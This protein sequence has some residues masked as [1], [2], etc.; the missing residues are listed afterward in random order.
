MKRILSIAV[1]DF[2]SSI[3]DFI[4]IYIIVSPIVLAFLIAGFVPSTETASVTIGVDQTIDNTIV[5]SLEAYVDVEAFETLEKMKN[6]V[7]ASDDFVGL[8]MAS[9]EGFEVIREGNEQDDASELIRNLLIKQASEVSGEINHIS[10]VSFSSIGVKE[11]PIAIIGL[12]SMAVL[13][14]VLGGMIVSMNIIEEKESMTFNALNAT[15]LTRFE[16]IVGKSLAGSI[17]A[18]LQIVSMFYIFGYNDVNILQ[19]LFIAIMGLSVVIIMGFILGLVSPSQMAAL[20]NMKILFL[21]ISIT[22]VGAIMLPSS[23]HF[24][25]WWSPFY[26]VYD[27]MTNIINETATWGGL[28]IDAIGVSVITLIIYM[29][30]RK[31]INQNM[32]SG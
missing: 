28:I 32:Q 20:A 7:N 26:W 23:S 19:V 8:T 17:I 31:K 9:E 4:A 1:R 15:P 14:L 16:Y 2:K 11:S 3:R 22:I 24:V 18:V 21:P 27:G 13:A 6:R 10:Q 25:L 12:V 29:V 30:F 5:E